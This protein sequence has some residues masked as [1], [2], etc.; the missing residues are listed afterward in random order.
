MLWKIL[1]FLVIVT[2]TW[3]RVRKLLQLRRLRATGQVPATPR[4]GIRPVSVL[5]AALIAVYG[6]YLLWIIIRQALP[7]L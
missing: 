1:T 2:F 5:A 4:K 7:G 6:G 3:W